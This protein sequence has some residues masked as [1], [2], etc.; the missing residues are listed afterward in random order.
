MSD[1]FNTDMLVDSFESREFRGIFASYGFD[2]RVHIPTCITCDVSTLLGL[3]I[4][5]VDSDW[6]TT[7]TVF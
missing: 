6:I 7:G 4:T 5:N 2:S 1:D 3:F